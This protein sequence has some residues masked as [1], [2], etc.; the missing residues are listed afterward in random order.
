MDKKRK[1]TFGRLQDF[2]SDES[3]TGRKTKLKLE[4]TMEGADQIGTKTIFEERLISL[5]GSLLEMR[6][7]SNNSIEVINA[8]LIENKNSISKISNMMETLV[9]QSKMANE[10]MTSNLEK[11]NFDL[12]TQIHE[13]I[14]NQSVINTQLN[15]KLTET[16]NKFENQTKNFTRGHIGDGRY[17]PNSRNESSPVNMSIDNDVPTFQ[18]LEYAEKGSHSRNERIQKT[19]IGL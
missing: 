6:L 14:A 15:N 9:N 4:D 5:E 18:Q 17:V 2:S 19:R 7:S 12:N 13:T 16:V 3:L 11:L 8:N 1:G 10:M